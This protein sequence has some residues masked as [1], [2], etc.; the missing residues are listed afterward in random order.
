MQAMT[1]TDSPIAPDRRVSRTES[2]VLEALR[3]RDR[4]TGRPRDWL[5]LR[6][7]KV[8]LAEEVGTPHL[9][10]LLDR[11]ADKGSLFQL[12]GGRYAVAPRGSV[13]VSQAMPF[14]VALDVAMGGRE[15]YLAFGSALADHGLID[16]NVDPIIAARASAVGGNDALSVQGLRV[17]IVRVSSDRRWFGREWVKGEAHSGYWRSDLER[18]VLD[19]VDRPDLCAGN[20][21]VARAWGRAVHEERLDADRLV[22]YATRMSGVSALRAAFY[23]QQLNQH[24]LAQR[25]LA[26]VPRTRSSKARLDLTRAFGPGKW[27]RDRATGL[28]IN[29][30]ES[31]LRGWLTYGK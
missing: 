16:E 13:D 25:I 30:P 4:A 24:D 7:D 17:T 6:R 15:Y 22:D 12:G 1:Q 8:W 3:R 21:L 19:A 10:Q 18:T 23:S 11:M 9:R 29:I 28:Q 31:R 27:P 5:D 14:S 26:V 20:E 2:R